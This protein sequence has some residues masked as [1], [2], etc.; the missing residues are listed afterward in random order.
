V[1]IESQL[2]AEISTVNRDAR[3]KLVQELAAAVSTQA[4]VVNRSWLAL[5]TVALFGVLPR[6]PG[7]DGN[8]SLPLNLGEVDPGWFHSVVF[9]ILVVL[10]IAF[11][12]A[13]AQQV[14][15]LKQAHAVIDSM[16]TGSKLPDDVHPRELFDM[17]RLPSLNRVAPLA[18]LLRG[19]Y[20]FFVN[21]RDCP[22]WLRAA[23]VGYYA[24]LK[25]ASLVVYFGLPSWALWAAYRNIPP[26]GRIGCFLAVG[27]ALAA[28]TLLHVLVSDVWYAAN[29]LRYLWLNPDSPQRDGA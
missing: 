11:A 28:V 21:S 18:Q 4:E 13:Q 29:I 3:R 1:N 14:R 10:T 26:A 19:R 22:A 16:V 27:G 12:A 5:M 6:I 7:H 20:Q 8:V 23:S 17:C 24:L 9:A 2:G 25:L 15:A